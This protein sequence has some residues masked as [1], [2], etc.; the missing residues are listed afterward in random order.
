MPNEYAARY[1]SASARQA[2]PR[3]VLMNGRNMQ[4]RRRSFAGAMTEPKVHPGLLDVPGTELL[5]VFRG[6]I[7]YLPLY[8]RRFALPMRPAGLGQ[9]GEF[10]SVAAGVASQAMTFIGDIIQTVVTVIAEILTT[11]VNFIVDVVGKIVSAVMGAVTGLLGGVLD[12][13]GL[14]KDGDLDPQKAAELAALLS[15]KHG[16]LTGHT[17]DLNR[18]MT[19]EERAAYER[20]LK[21][22]KDGIKE[23]GG[24]EALVAAVGG[25]T[26]AI[27]I[28]AGAAAAIWLSKK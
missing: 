28:A 5:P 18:P 10:F 27:A 15:A 13:I 12:A 2:P 4:A 21:D 3:Y 6:R 26:G 16:T 17:N 22:S 9:I 25:T 11:I 1:L 23:L 24:A 19:A 20:N 8:N 14:K 7:L